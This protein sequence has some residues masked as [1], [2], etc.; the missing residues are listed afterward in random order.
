MKQII[1]AISMLSV[2]LALI[3]GVVIPIFE[4][5]ESTGGSAVLKGQSVITRVG[6]LIK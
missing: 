2:G 4:R 3:I 1:I 6:Q 5:G